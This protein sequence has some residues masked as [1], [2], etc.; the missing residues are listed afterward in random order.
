MDRGTVES[1]LDTLVT[2]NRFT[3][4]VVFP[5]IGALLLVGSAEGWVPA[6]LSFEP[7]LILIGTAVMRLPLIAGVLP[8]LD[9]R[10]TLGVLGLT[11]YA[12]GIEL[13]GVQTGLPYG[14]FWYLIDLGPMLFG[15]VPVGLPV[16]FLP[17]VLNSYLLVILLLGPR[18]ESTSL[19]LAGTLALV[20]VMD[21]VLDPGAVGLGFWAY[22]DGGGYY[23]VPSINFLG[24]VLSGGI[25]VWVFDKILA[26]DLLI[27]RLESCPFMLDDMVSFVILWGGINLHFGQWIPVA[28]A[29]LMGIGLLRTERFDF[30][31]RPQ[32][33][34]WGRRWR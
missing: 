8:L 4:A 2:E 27:E 21:L 28:L 20:L 34:N 15:N 14:E 25:S 5:T 12:Y 13:I 32:L 19:R 31:V 7:T 30:A 17:L 10:G 22:V 16:F 23:G 6:P 9:R 29:A 1:R 3:I 33:L 18:A 24:W 11:G 26:R